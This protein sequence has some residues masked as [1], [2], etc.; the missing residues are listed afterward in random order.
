MQLN[1]IHITILGMVQSGGYDAFQLDSS[2]DVD[3]AHRLL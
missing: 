1:H 2:C 3:E